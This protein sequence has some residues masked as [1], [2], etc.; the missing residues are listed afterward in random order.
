MDTAP[1]YCVSTYDVLFSKQA[2]NGLIMYDDWN[3]HGRL[4]S[5]EISGQELYTLFSS[6]SD[7]IYEAFNEIKSIY[8]ADDDTNGKFY[9]VIQPENGGVLLAIG[10]D[11]DEKEIRLIRWLFRLEKITDINDEASDIDSTTYNTN[12]SEFFLDNEDSNKIG[13]SIQ[14]INNSDLGEYSGEYRIMREGQVIENLWQSEM[15]WY[16]EEVCEGLG[17]EFVITRE[18]KGFYGSIL[19]TEFYIENNGVRLTFSG[20]IGISADAHDVAVYDLKEKD[21]ELNVFWR[22]SHIRVEILQLLNQLEIK[23]DLDEDNKLIILK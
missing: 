21:K 1:Q 15:G 2:V 13:D 20:R 11:N 16:L 14:D 5:Y 9:L 10:Y 17:I 8:R 3:M 22:S 4:N 23:Y 18:E 12:L 6:P 7:S 19:P